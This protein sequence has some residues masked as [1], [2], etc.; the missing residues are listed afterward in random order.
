MRAP[1]LRAIAAAADRRLFEDYA[2]TARGLACLRVFYATLSLVFV[3]QFDW[4]GQLPD[5]L[6]APPWG[7]LRLL[8]G[9]PSTSVARGIEAVFVVSVLA[10]L[11]GCC[12]RTASVLTGLALGVG[13]GVTFGT[14]KVDS[15]GLGVLLPFVLAMTD[16]GRAWSVDAWRRKVPDERPVRTWP[17]ALIAL[18]LGV[19][20]FTAAY[21][22]V[23]GGWLSPYTQ[24]VRGHFVTQYFVHDRTDLLATAAL[25]LPGRLPWEALDWL[26]VLVE[27]AFLPAALLGRRAL[28]G[29]AAV[30]TLLHLSIMLVINIPFLSALVVYSVFLPWD[31]VADRVAG[32][33]SRSG[34][35]RRARPAAS[36]WWPALAGVL[37]VGCALYLALDWTGQPA[38]WV[39][40][41]ALTQ[42]RSQQVVALVL[43]VAAAVIGGAH[44]LNE[45]RDAARR[46][47]GRAHAPR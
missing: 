2:L 11:V 8:D 33:V 36:A 34:L 42:E 27:G 13:F 45:S 47:R 14:G 32:A 46:V 10:L 35:S 25:Q 7:P 19:A 6:W 17:L 43:L 3:P 37:V 20:M 9:Y 41:A 39:L 21:P 16:W 23:G 4:V 29:V 30:A 28:R 22:K 26:T 18:M 12:T 40:S 31:A 15:V 1:G 5:S 44:L 38:A 24:A